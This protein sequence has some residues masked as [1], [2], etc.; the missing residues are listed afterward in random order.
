MNVVHHV[1]ED[2]GAAAD[3]IAKYR[4]GCS[5]Q[6]RIEGHD[7]EDPVPGRGALF[8]MWPRNGRPAL[9]DGQKRVVLVTCIRGS[10][11]QTKLSE[12][13]YR[14]LTSRDPDELI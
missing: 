8:L 6:H 7:A 13:L 9:I 1:T 14:L 5:Y 12:A 4:E 2:G 3:I 10:G 11:T